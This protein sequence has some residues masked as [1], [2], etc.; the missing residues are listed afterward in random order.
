MVSVAVCSPEGEVLARGSSERPMKHGESLA[1]LVQEVLHEAAVKPAQLTLVG[2]GTGPG[3]FTGLRV[4]LVTARMLGLA[5]GI[6]VRGVCSLDV[7]AA[8]AVAGGVAEPFVVVTDARRK[9]LFHASYDD[10]GRRRAGPDVDRPTDVLPAGDTTLVVGPAVDLYP[11]TFTRTTGPD[12]V[13]AATLATLL[14]DSHAVV[15]DPVPLYLRRPD[16]VVPGPPKQA[17]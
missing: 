8:Q 15:T 10:Q 11:G 7:I 2:A 9:E 6:P 17:S 16:A 14:L 5:L 3:P 12:Q 1:P 13:E 4:G